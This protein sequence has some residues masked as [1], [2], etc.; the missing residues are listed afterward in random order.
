[1]PVEQRAEKESLSLPRE[2]VITSNIAMSSKT[3]ERTG[4]RLQRTSRIRQSREFVKLREAQIR[5][6]TRNFVLLI[7]PSI[8]PVSRLGVTVSSRVDKRAAVR[9]RIKRLI[10]ESFRRFQNKLSDS[11]DIVVIARKNIGRSS[12]E[13]VESE[14]LKALCHARL[15]KR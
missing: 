14:L 13:L 3:K 2:R 9:N 6:H 1:M 12:L 7:E 4:T 8:G 10:R 5:E 15:L 11:F